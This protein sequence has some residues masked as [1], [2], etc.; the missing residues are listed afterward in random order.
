MHITISSISMTLTYI[1]NKK[2]Q[3]KFHK[4]HTIFGHHV[5]L[6]RRLI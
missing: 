4:F 5:H 6:N 3:K 1:V 2:L